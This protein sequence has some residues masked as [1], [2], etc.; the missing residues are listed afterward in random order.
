MKIAHVSETADGIVVQDLKEHLGH[1]AELCSGYMEYIGC[2]A[3]G[4]LVGILH[5]AGKCLPP[6]Q[7]RMEAIR[8]G[9]PDPGQKGGHASGGAVFLEKTA[10]DSGK[11]GDLAKLFAI[12]SMCEA[13]F[14]HHASLPD[15]V[16]PDGEDGYEKRMDCDEEEL[17][18]IE[19]YLR[20]EIITEEKLQELLRQ[21]YAEAGELFHK[22]R[23]HTRNFREASFYLGCF[24]KM[25]LSVLI[26]A[27]WLDSAMS[28][29]S[30]MPDFQSVI[31][32]ECLYRTE[33]QRLFRTFLGNLEQNL[34]KMNVSQNAIHFWRNYISQCCKEAGNRKGG[35]YTLSCPTGAGKTLAALRFSLS[36]CIEQKKDKIFYIIPY[37]SVIDQ[38][39]KSIKKALKTEL[40]T[41][42]DIQTENSILELHSNAEPYKGSECCTDKGAEYG[43][44]SQDRS[45]WAQRMAEPIVLTTMVRFLNTFFAAGTRNLRPAHRFRNAVLLFDEIQTL[46]VKQVAVFNS[47][48]NYLSEVCGCTCVLC[49]ATQ[50]LLGEV[51]EPVYPV[52]M[53]Q[54][55]GLAE[56]PEEAV[57]VFKRVRIQDGR[58]RG[59]Y[60]GEELA[61]FVWDRAK[62]NESVLAV[63]NTKQSALTV[64]QEV[65][66]RAEG[67][68]QVYYLST[69]LYAAHRKEII[70]EIRTALAA[71]E[72]I[73]VV[74]TQLI[75]AGI[76]FDFGCVI[77]SLAGMDSV[78]QAA[79]RCNREGKR[80]TGTVY[81]VNPG[82]K[83]ESLAHLKDIGEGARQTDRLL[84][85][86]DKAPDNFDYDLL[87]DKAIR[88]YFQ[89]YFW[90]RKNEMVYPIPKVS[91][92]SL[93]DLLSDNKSLLDSAVKHN[94][95]KIK[96]LNQAF[97]TAANYYN[98]IETGG[99]P[100]F[101]RRGRGKEIWEEIQRASEYKEIKQLLKEAQ[102]FVVNVPLYELK[103]L[104]E[105]KGV[106]QWEDKMGM[107]VLN[108]MYYDDRTGLSGEI[109]DTMPQY[110]F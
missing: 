69:R 37:M 99:D 15:N 67:E 19:S 83:L 29:G 14:S 50:P 6:F 88:T 104:G 57:N 2:S 71:G 7:A 101:I 98:V 107:Y 21:A 75:E 87:S 77:R 70:E 85:E 5:D 110:V 78:V 27:D 35:I 73:I 30:S 34:Q 24:Q 52:K 42:F 56:L 106:I 64:Y 105:S 81:I 92:Y 9:R 25:L 51:S 16:S 80:E 26:D 65:I 59:G 47:L 95:Y 61:G 39:A 10:G 60:S 90:N 38:T 45:F 96:A 3:M 46:P 108:E 23:K 44:C 68:F 49:T 109:G 58:K 62:E 102:Q 53:A 18:E 91:E 63:M 11:S 93:Y 74:S 94:A 103:K 43:E 40:Q 28:G 76:D 100:V 89:Y 84:S 66:R 20:K 4:Y 54:P 12:Q 82:D 86:F 13:V 79:G 22:V 36:H 1:V 55:P 48:I 72:K 41:D 31:E 33:R 8:S 17:R 97:H 32:R